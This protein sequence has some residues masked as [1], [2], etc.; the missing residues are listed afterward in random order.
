MYNNYVLI[1]KD[2]LRTIEKKRESA[3]LERKIES[4]VGRGQVGGRGEVMETHCS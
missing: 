2:I 1:K 4:W 3:S